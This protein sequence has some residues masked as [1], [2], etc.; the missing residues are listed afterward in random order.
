VLVRDEVIDAISQSATTTFDLVEPLSAPEVQAVRFEGPDTIEA[1]AT[2]SYRVW[3]E[4]LGDRDSSVVS[5]I[6]AR[7]PDGEWQTLSGVTGA[8]NLPGGGQ[9]YYAVDGAQID[10]PGEYDYRLDDVEVGWTLV[11]VE[12]S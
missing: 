2:F 5:P 8:A 7:P 10:T 12:S 6:S 1:G 9:G 11:V 4:N 3:M